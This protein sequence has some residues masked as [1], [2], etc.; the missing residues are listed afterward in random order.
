[1]S[2]KC[3]E[4]ID[5]LSEE[6]DICSAKGHRLNVNDIA[7]EKTTIKARTKLKT[8]CAGFIKDKGKKHVSKDKL[9]SNAVT[10]TNEK[11]KS[12]KSF[13]ECAEDS[14]ESESCEDELT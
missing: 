4:C 12:K 8:S 5:E 6:E 13:A 11:E 9:N 14:D 3:K 2:V 10:T 7:G 1:M